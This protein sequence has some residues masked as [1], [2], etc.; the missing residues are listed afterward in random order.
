MHASEHAARCVEK[1]G[2]PFWEVH[3]WLDQYFRTYRGLPHRIILHHRLGM[4]LAGILFGPEAEAAARLHIMDD[5]GRLPLGP[6]DLMARPA[7]QPSLGEETNLVR[8][9]KEALGYKAD[10]YTD[11]TSKR[12]LRCPC[13]YRGYFLKTEAGELC[14][15]CRG[16]GLDLHNRFGI[17]A[18]LAVGHRFR[19]TPLSAYQIES[20]KSGKWEF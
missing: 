3:T 7:Y 6:E 15:W 18:E 12:N 9:L 10:F 19:K 8:H 17:L 16:Q 20:L 13:G 1:L 14:P 4:K 11:W 5:Q 2:A